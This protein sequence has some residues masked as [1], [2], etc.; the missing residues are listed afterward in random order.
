MRLLSTLAASLAVQL[1]A[2]TAAAATVSASYTGTITQDSGL[3]FIGQQLRADI[4]WDT[5]VSGTAIGNSYFYQDALVSLVVSIGANSWTY[6][7]TGGFDSVF[8]YNDSVLTFAIG[9]EDRVNLDAGTFTG[10]DLGTGTVLNESFNFSLS[11]QD[12]VPSG[13]PDGLDAADTLPGTALIP[14]LFTLDIPELGTNSMS[15]S[16]FTGTDPELGGEFFRIGTQSVATVPV[17]AAAWL[18]ASAL[19]AGSLR[20]R[21]R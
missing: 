13:A 14:E 7:A 6:D 15:F 21:R 12:N 4:S 3:G 19:A 16:W 20:R 8:L 11:L 18:F 9:V 17:P 10:P 1:A 5:S 2:G